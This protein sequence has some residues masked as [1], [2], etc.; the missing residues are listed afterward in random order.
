MSELLPVQLEQSVFLD[1]QA[2]LCIA[3]LLL[4]CVAGVKPTEGAAR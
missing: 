3:E 2:S 4:T 1:G